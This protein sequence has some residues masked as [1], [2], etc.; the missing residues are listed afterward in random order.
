[1]QGNPAELTKR[2]KQVLELVASGMTDHEIAESLSIA[3]RTVNWHVANIYSKSD[4]HD[5]KKIIYYSKAGS[6]AGANHD[7][8]W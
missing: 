5:R 2:E 8:E 6:I 1:M 7:N 4:I 3:V